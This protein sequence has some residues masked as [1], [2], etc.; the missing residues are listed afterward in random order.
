MYFL[1]TFGL[2]VS[3]FI[4]LPYLLYKFCTTEKYRQGFGERLGLLSPDLTALKTSRPLWVHGVSVGEITAAAPLVAALQEE[5][6]TVP[7]LVS[8]GTV[9]GQQTARRQMPQIRHFLY[10]PFDLPWIVQRVIEQLNPRG[11]VLIETEIWPNFL[12]ALAQRQIPVLLVN[13]RISPRSFRGYSRWAFFMRKVL[14]NLTCCSMQTTQDAERI[15]AIGAPRERVVVTGN[16]K[17]DQALV[18]L[19]RG[20]PPDFLPAWFQE[21]E[22][23]IAGS[24]HPGEEEQILDVY[25]ELYQEFPALLLILAPRHIERAAEVIALIHKRGLPAVRRTEISPLA[26]VPSSRPFPVLVLDTLGELS[27]LYQKG[28]IIFVGGSL[29]PIGGHNILEPLVYKR[30]VLYGPYMHNF[31]EI[32]TLVEARQGGRRVQQAAELKA[33]IRE[34]LGDQEQREAMG[35]R[36]YQVIQENRGAVSRNLALLARYIPLTASDRFP[37]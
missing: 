35:A 23:F 22:L 19:K 20:Q 4:S 15:C 21:K 10:F 31:Q 24:T 9:T 34:L 29:V 6:P 12:R 13:G 2:T 25:Q 16:I 26:P 14:A 32:A 7:L 11:V 30:A 17:F 33:V 36:G 18:S 8:T 1:Y 28:T 37:T 3:A 5:Y 27:S